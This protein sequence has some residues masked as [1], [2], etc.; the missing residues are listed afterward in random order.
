MVSRT[1]TVAMPKPRIPTEAENVIETVQL[2]HGLAY[3][4]ATIAK[5]LHIDQATTLHVI[6]NG[7]L[8]ARQLSLVWKDL[9]ATD[10]ERE[11]SR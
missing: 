5:N 2:L 10:Y 8:P 1:T 4:A 7:A 3:D 9:P 11:M 6:K